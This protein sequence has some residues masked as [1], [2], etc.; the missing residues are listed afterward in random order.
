MRARKLNEEKYVR[1]I[2]GR[3]VRGMQASVS[4]KKQRVTYSEF[5]GDPH[6]PTPRHVLLQERQLEGGD[7]VAEFRLASLVCKLKINAKGHLIFMTR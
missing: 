2:K 3:G 1:P 6:D 7:A 5:V 4:D